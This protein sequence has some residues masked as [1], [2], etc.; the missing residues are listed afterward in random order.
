M[1]FTGLEIY[2]FNSGEHCLNVMT[3]N[4]LSLIIY[5][6]NMFDLRQLP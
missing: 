4:M 1:K 2:L 6:T 5:F 3:C